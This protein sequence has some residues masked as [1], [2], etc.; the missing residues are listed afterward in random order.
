MMT[1]ETVCACL[2]VCVRA[3]AHTQTHHPPS[4]DSVR[5]HRC[6]GLQ[7][8]TGSH[9]GPFRYDGHRS[10]SHE[11]GSSTH[12][13]GS[14]ELRNGV[15][16]WLAEVPGERPAGKGPQLAIGHPEVDYVTRMKGI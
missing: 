8:D 9:P 14:P 12:S 16:G 6:L 13:V 7:A 2:Y 4:P 3:C 10:G 1:K 5:P 11:D 15:E